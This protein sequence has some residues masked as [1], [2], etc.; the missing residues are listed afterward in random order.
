MYIMK[1]LFEVIFMIVG[2]RSNCD[3]CLAGGKSSLVNRIIG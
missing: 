1:T 2:I 3:K